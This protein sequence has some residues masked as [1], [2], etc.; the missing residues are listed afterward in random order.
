[1]GHGSI[2][3]YWKFWVQAGAKPSE[4]I[5]APCAFGVDVDA[6]IRASVT[7]DI[8]SWRAICNSDF[9]AAWDT[10]SAHA[11]EANPF[12]ESWFMLPTLDQFD[13]DGKVRFAS[14]WNGTPQTGNLIGMMPVAAEK[15][16]GRWPI[17]YLSNWLHSNAFLGTPI[18]RRGFEHQFWRAILPTLDHAVGLNLFLHISGIVADGPLAVAMEAVAREQGRKFAQVHRLERAILLPGLNPATYFENAVRGKKRKELRRQKNRLSELGALTFERQADD[19]ALAAWTEEF[20]ALEQS[21]WKGE[22]GS[23]LACSPQTRRMFTEALSGAAAHAKLERLT[24]RLDGRP[25]AMLVNF[26]AHGGSFSFK[27]AFDEDLARFSPGVLLQID[28][29]ELLVQPDF[30]YCDSCAAE[31]HPMIDSLWI[32]RRVIG[33]YSVAIGGGVRRAAFGL[34]LGAERALARR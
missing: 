3:A 21:G 25:I 5:V 22:E 12:N 1:L 2:W 16:Y 7:L 10:L 4:A 29:L 11:S 28:N 23:A 8:R 24:Y 32:D 13:P 26:H 30:Q 19:Q 17:P 33:R 9:I 18:V 14:V 20:L 15:K 6:G 34:L 31:G 27:T